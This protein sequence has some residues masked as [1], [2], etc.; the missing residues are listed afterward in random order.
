MGTLIVMGDSFE[1][2]RGLGSAGAVPRGA[3]LGRVPPLSRQ[4]GRSGLTV[5]LEARSISS[6]PDR[7]ASGDASGWL[8]RGAG[9]L[10]RGGDPNFRADPRRNSEPGSTQLRT[11]GGE[12]LA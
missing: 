10:G 2:K 5:S 8:N 9:R 4:L 1:T 7:M 3:P 12:A 6:P 11:Q